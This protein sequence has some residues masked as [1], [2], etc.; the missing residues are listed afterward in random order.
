MRRREFITLLGAGAAAAWPL[1][2][3][4]QHRGK[5]PT[6]G[7]LG[8]TTAEAQS[9]STHAFAQR[10]RELGWIEGRNV[11][12]NYRWAEGQTER[13]SEIAAEFVRLDVDAIVTSGAGAAAA[14]KV[15]SVIPIVFTIAAD[16][17][18]SGLVASLARPGGNVT[19][20]S[21]QQADLA[22]KRIGLLREVAPSFRRL[23]ILANVG[24][25]NPTL[26]M[27]EAQ[28]AASKLGLQVTTLGIRRAGTSNL[29][30]RPLR[31]GRAYFMS[32]ATRSSSRT[33]F[34]LTPW[35]WDCDCR[36]FS[37]VGRTP[38][39]QV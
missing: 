25:P 28:A 35:R 32:V 10:L 4:A 20:L 29:P 21:A 1:A 14:R 27:S 19:G 16:P 13:F 30:S 23:A 36:Q 11:A 12:I 9:Q 5:L 3:R 37:L 26:E 8:V 39:Q 18:G 34:A 15:T 7:Y 38:K 33:G 2:A 6:I 24:A 22:G 17:L 31:V